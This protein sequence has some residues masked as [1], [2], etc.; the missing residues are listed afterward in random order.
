VATILKML[1]GTPLENPF[2]IMGGK[3]RPQSTGGGAGQS[4]GGHEKNP[5]QMINALLNPSMLAEMEKIRGIGIGVQDIGEGKN[6]PAI[7]VLFPGKSDALKGLLQMA[8]TGLGSPADRSRT[9]R[10]DVR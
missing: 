2:N 8:M 5:V 7:I 6:Q 4:S 10:P 3:D 1:K 9:W